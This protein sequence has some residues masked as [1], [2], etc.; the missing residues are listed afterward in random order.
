LEKGTME[1]SGIQIRLLTDEK[2]GLYIKCQSPLG[3][4]YHLQ[5]L[6]LP[7]GLKIQSIDME[8]IKIQVEQLATEY[9]HQGLCPNRRS[10]NQGPDSSSDSDPNIS[11]DS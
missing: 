2:P 10:E 11:T 3:G 7:N 6:Y 9:F 5:I 1:V 4:I 8:K